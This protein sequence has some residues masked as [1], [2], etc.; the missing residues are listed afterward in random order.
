MDKC[1]VEMLCVNIV[2]GEEGG[3]IMDPGIGGVEWSGVE[4]V[5]FLLSFSAF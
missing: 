4:E 1:V 3:Q 2:D 5:E